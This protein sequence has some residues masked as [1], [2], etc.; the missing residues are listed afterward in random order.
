MKRFAAA[1][2]AFSLF[3]AVLPAVAAA[4]PATGLLADINVARSQQGLSPLHL[5][6]RL[7]RV[8][9]AHSEA[10]ARLGFF[11]HRGA[12]GKEIADR[13]ADAGYGFLFAGENLS[14]GIDNPDT[15]VKQWL[16]SR[17]HR[18]NLLEPRAREAGIGFIAAPHAQ[19][20]Y[21]WTLILAEPAPR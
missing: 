15:V 12:D 5:V 11:D 2:A 18:A 20:R 21:Y 9:R 1:F 7:S 8:A 14:A 10:M 4:D 6:A 17:G 19:Y 3:L 16:L 13:L